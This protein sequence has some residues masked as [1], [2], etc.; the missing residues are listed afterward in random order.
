MGL[1]RNSDSVLME[2]YAPLLVNVSPADP[3]K[4]YPKA[5]QW[6]TNLIGYD[7]LHSFGSASYYAQVMLAQNKGDVVLP[8]A[9]A[10]IEK[11]ATTLWW[12]IGCSL[13]F[14]TATLSKADKTVLIKVVNAGD[15]ATDI[16]IRVESAAH[17]EPNGTAIVLA[18]DPSWVNTVD[19][20]RKVSPQQEAVTNAAPSFH[21]SFPPHSFTILRVKVSAQ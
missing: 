16:E 14:A 17:I 19:E 11:G 9:L 1:E 21:R 13:I 7:A 8:A 20:P 6:N 2:C 3:D 10:V 15:A 4:G 12:G 18:G 5:M